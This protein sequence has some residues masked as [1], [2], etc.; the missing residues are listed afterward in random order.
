MEPA[1]NRFLEHPVA[2]DVTW[3][4][5]VIH[6][7]EILQ[8]VDVQ[9]LGLGNIS[10]GLCVDPDAERVN[11]NS[12]ETVDRLALLIDSLLELA[13]LEDPG[14]RPQH[15]VVASEAL[16]GPL[17]DQLRGSG[18]SVACD[19]ESVVW[20]QK[21]QELLDKV[22]EEPPSE[23]SPPSLLN[24]SCSLDLIEEF[25]AAA[26]EFYQSRFWL[27][28]ND[29]DLLQIHTPKPPYGL[30]WATVLG[31]GG[32]EYGLGFYQSEDM[33]WALRAG[34]LDPNSIDLF[35]MR[36][37]PLS[38]A[39]PQDQQYWQRAE[40]PL[41]SDDAF[42]QLL[43]FIPGGVQLPKTKEMELVTILLKAL[44]RTSEAELDSGLWI[45]PVPVRGKQKRCKVSIPNLL[46]PPS[47]EDWLKRGVMPDQRLNER[48]LGQAEALIAEH[49]GE[50]DLDQLNQLLNEKLTGSLDEIDPPSDTA[51]DRAE[52]LCFQALEQQ[53]RNRVRLIRQALREDPMHLRAHELLAENTLDLQTRIERYQ[54]ALELGQVQLKDL[55]ETEVGHFW[56][57]LKTRPFIRA[58]HGLALALEENGQRK[59]AIEQMLDILRLNT[60][61]NL[62]V[63]YRLV[64]LLMTQDRETEAAQILEQYPDESA[65]WWYLK[66]LVEFCLQGPAS[67]KAQETMLKAFAANPHVS[68]LIVRGEPPRLPESYS[69]GSVEEAEVILEEQAEAW[70]TR[71]DFVGWMAA[72]KKFLDQENAKGKRSNK[73]GKP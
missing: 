42:P 55:W 23:L 26:A 6:L 24:S 47:R 54:A 66:A 28:L 30:Q 41:A 9:G 1:L 58:K 34:R 39:A 32:Q 61:D 70:M 50:M 35:S 13:E 59:E 19:P 62:G 67:D 7:S 29:R 38:E 64:A 43:H 73:R 45:K 22:L 33:H 60:N 10:L 40:L 20:N 25:A 15:I 18:T 16:F 2:A 63:R 31:S 49:Q 48:H 14:Y 36:Y 71:P 4:V 56:Q 17:Q 68:E 65:A 12:A 52:E 11:V 72:G 57:I 3:H 51:F 46:H 21:R 69:P 53:G 8:A 44:A 37:I 5:G 27:Q